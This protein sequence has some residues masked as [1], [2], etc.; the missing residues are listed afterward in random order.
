M[1]DVIL[2]PIYESEIYQYHEC[3]NCK[4]EIYLEE[5]I[6]KPFHFDERIK[7]CPFCGNKIVR[8]AEPKYIKEI[9]WTWLEEYSEIIEKTY[10][11]LEYKIHCKMNKEQIRELEDKS[12]RGIEYFKQDR[13]AFPYSNGIVC[14]IVHQ[15]AREKVHYTTKQKLEKEFNK[16]R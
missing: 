3:S 10:K 6:F 4:K 14:D 15:I 1:G 13:W 9:D 11:F 12:E 16:S 5:D 8:Y 2:T 7:Y